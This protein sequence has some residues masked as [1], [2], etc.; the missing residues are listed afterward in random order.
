MPSQSPPSLN[1]SSPRLRALAGR[2]AATS[3]AELTEHCELCGAPVPEEHRHLLELDTRQLLCACRPC[4]LLFDRQAA[5]GG[6]YRLVPERRLRLTGF[7]LSDAAWER[8]QIPVE[9]AFFFFNSSA[10]RVM[11]F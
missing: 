1:L 8:L 2:R 5:G 9:M 6:H 11:A 7:E 10:E 3:S 4:A